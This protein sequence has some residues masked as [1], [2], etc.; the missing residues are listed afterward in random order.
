LEN[1]SEK[2]GKAGFLLLFRKIWGGGINLLVMAY[3]ARVLSPVDFGLVAISNTLINFVHVFGSIGIGDYLIY[4]RGENEKEVQNAA[5]W[6]NCLMVVMVTGFILAIAPYW[7]TRYGDPRI[8]TLIWLMTLGFVFNTLSGIPQ[9]LLRK[10]LEYKSIVFAA[11]ILGTISQ[12]SQVALAYV[13]AG[14]YALA[15][16]TAVITPISCGLIFHYS[17]FKPSISQLGVKHWSS[18]IRYTKH[19]VGA[20]FITKIANEGDNLILGSTL[21]MQA[22]GL[23]DIAFK[24]ANIFNQHLLPIIT[25]I[26]M[27]VFSL[28]QHD[29]ERTG[30]HYLK[31]ISVIAFAFFPLY[32]IMIVFS[33]DIIRLLYGEK[34]QAAALPLQILAS[35]A[36]FRSLSSPTSGLFNALGK[37]QLGFYYT[38]IFTPLFLTAIY[39]ASFYGLIVTCVIVAACRIIGSVIQLSMARYRLKINPQAYLQSFIPVLLAVFMSSMAIFSI[40]PHPKLFLIPLFSIIF[41]IIMR[42]LFNVLFNEQLVTLKKMIPIVRINRNR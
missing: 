30:Q 11:G 9:S 34:W 37:P 1:L 26:S 21:G 24:F 42:I 28:N 29:L 31:M 23:Y 17:K 41:L 4:Y 22:L 35:F 38:I 14:V 8:N 5:F 10:K 13:G 3:L 15:I 20:Q 36:L 19:L 12:I 25:N 33:E 40:T 7:A 2:V 27:P 32:G 39:F 16:P 18:I 6:L